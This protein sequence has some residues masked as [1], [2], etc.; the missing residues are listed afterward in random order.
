V[1]WRVTM[2]LLCFCTGVLK[3]LYCA[4]P[5]RVL[6]FV[7]CRAITCYVCVVSCPD[8]LQCLC[9]VVPWRVQML[10]DHAASER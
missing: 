4:V 7:W 2:F 6:M 8:M 9:C 10:C 5:W 1:L 3:F